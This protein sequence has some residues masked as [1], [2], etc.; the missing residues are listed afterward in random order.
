[1][2]K[3]FG[4]I[5]VA[6]FIAPKHLEAISKSKNNL[7]MTLDPHDSV[8]ILDKF[9]PNALFFNN[10]KDFITSPL[11]KKLDFISICSPNYLHKS[12]I[13]LSLSNN[14]I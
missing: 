4:L 2:N 13:H 8:G 7:L 3:N 14:I 12:H 1:M 11:L 9:F 6:G 5:G 10:E